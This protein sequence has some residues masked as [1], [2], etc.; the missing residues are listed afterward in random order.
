MKQILISILISIVVC[1]AGCDE[2]CEEGNYKPGDCNESKPI[3]GEVILKIT[4]D[5]MNAMVPVE[6]FIG[7]VEENI[8][9]FADTI[10][11]QS[12]SYTLPNNRYAVR[13]KYKAI[14]N[15]KLVTVY[16]IDGGSLD[17]NETDYCDG[18]C[19]ENGSLTLDAKL[20]L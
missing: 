20:E 15:G 6:F 17:A 14:I 19:Y 3:E 12:V 4:I 10:V 18:D 5:N 9:Y 1:V 2:E 11:T 13:A 8:F 7:D 16:S